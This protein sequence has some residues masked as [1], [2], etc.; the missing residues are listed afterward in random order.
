MTKRILEVPRHGITTHV[1]IKYGWCACRTNYPSLY[2]V[3]GLGLDL[4]AQI[5]QAGRDHGL[6]GYVYYRELCGLRKPVSFEDM[7][8]IMPQEVVDSLRNL[9]K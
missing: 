9:Y 7:K 6:P 4:A 8:E 2:S 1:E 5:I 3:S